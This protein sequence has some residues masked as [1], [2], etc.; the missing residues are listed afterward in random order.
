MCLH[1]QSIYYL[2]P[3]GV[4]ARAFGCSVST[5]L[6]MSASHADV[7]IEFYCELNHNLANKHFIICNV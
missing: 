6:H 5:P 3:G 2:V 7:L 4:L 1:M